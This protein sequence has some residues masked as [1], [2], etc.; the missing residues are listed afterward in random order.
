MDFLNKVKKIKKTASNVLKNHK[1]PLSI[2]LKDN[3]NAMSFTRLRKG[4]IVISREILRYH[5]IEALV[6]EPFVELDYIACTE[7]GVK[8]GVLIKKLKT[9]VTAEIGM[10]IEK[11]MITFVEQQ[12][13][14]KISN[15]KVVGNNLSGK[16]LSVLARTIIS[17]LVKK[18]IFTIDLP[19]H[20]NKKHNIATLDL[21]EI[22]A[23]SSMKKPVLASKSVLEFI[24]VVGAVH[25]DIGIIIKC[26]VKVF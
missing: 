15:E 10:F 1:E 6:P 13:I 24:S 3:F 5:I 23:I 4:E 12:I 16:L 9:S 26:K 22:P 25:T 11:A 2:V 18:A 17:G 7:S 19:I 8:V 14:I 21:S 20:Y